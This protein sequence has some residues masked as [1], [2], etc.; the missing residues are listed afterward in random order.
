MR[1]TARAL[2]GMVREGEDDQ[3][4]FAKA[5]VGMLVLGDA[6]H[7]RPRFSLV[8]PCTA[9]RLVVA[10]KIPIVLLLVA[11]LEI[12]RQVARVHVQPRLC[13]AWPLPATTSLAARRCGRR[14]QRRECAGHV[15][16]AKIV[17]A[18]PPLGGANEPR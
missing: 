7:R 16:E 3:V 1:P 13:G 14:R 4:A 2:P 18:T 10:L 6:G 8:C 17:T 9:P 15:F 5:D 11:V 12:A